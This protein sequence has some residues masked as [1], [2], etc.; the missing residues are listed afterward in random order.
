MTYV[1]IICQHIRKMNRP[2]KAK[3]IIERTLILKKGSTQGTI[4]QVLHQMVDKGVLVTV[5]FPGTR[6]YYC[7]PEW[8]IGGKLTME[9]NP[10]WDKQTTTDESKQISL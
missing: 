5:R 7:N 10:N 2:L 6:N 1:E 3:E 8:V 4:R 9:F